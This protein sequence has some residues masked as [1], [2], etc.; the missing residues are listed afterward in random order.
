MTVGQIQT[1]VAAAATVACGVLLLVHPATLQVEHWSK[2][3]RIAFAVVA[4]IV[5]IFLAVN[6]AIS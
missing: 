3:K 2:D 6:T 5:A 1:L 4:F